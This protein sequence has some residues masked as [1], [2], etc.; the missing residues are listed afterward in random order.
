MKRRL[1]LL[2]GILFALSA[3]GCTTFKIRIPGDHKKIIIEE[4]FNFTYD[5]ELFE[6]IS[7]EM[8]RGLK[9]SPD[10]LYPDIVLMEVTDSKNL[11][12][13]VL[14][15]Q[16]DLVKDDKIIRKD[17]AICYGPILNS[18]KKYNWD[19]N[20]FEAQV[21]NTGIHE[22]L[23]ANYDDV[24]KKE[25]GYLN[26]EKGVSADKHCQNFYNMTECVNLIKEFGNINTFDHCK[27]IETGDL[28]LYTTITDEYFNN[29]G[30][31][32]RNSLENTDEDCKK[33]RRKTE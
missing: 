26:K 1:L 15:F 18:A 32:Q 10:A 2:T 4:P 22:L 8:R 3:N 31:A 27:M 20:T 14:G 30:V 17:A 29:N 12:K 7:S 33:N 23:H 11:P 5:L 13:T 25:H 28:K 9:I 19:Q 6:K 16:F 24:Y 21:Y